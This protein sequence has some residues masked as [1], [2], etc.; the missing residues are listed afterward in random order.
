VGPLGPGVAP[1]YLH[2]APEPHQL[3]KGPA[4]SLLQESLLGLQVGRA[5]RG[6]APGSLDGGLRGQIRPG[7]GVAAVPGTQ[8]TR[9]PPSALRRHRFARRTRDPRGWG[10]HLGR[11]RVDQHRRLQ[12]LLLEPLE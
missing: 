3:V 8:L 11:Q 2:G 10:V 5:G 12:A 6:L 7:L 1:V 9:R 4:L